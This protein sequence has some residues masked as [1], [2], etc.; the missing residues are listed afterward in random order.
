[1]IIKFVV[2]VKPAPMKEDRN[3]FLHKNDTLFS[4]KEKLKSP[5]I[6]M[7]THSTD[8]K[9]QVSKSL[10]K[11]FMIHNCNYLQIIACPLFDQ[12]K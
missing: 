8:V 3:R 4:K 9:S 5:F 11:N 12:F 1:M 6:I 10:R 7:K 2:V